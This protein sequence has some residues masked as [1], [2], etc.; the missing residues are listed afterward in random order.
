MKTLLLGFVIMAAMVTPVAVG[1]QQ[2]ERA[3]V[4]VLV[5]GTP[6]GFASYIEV[7]R[8]RLRELGWIEGQNLVLD[9]RYADDN[10]D[11]LP[12]LATELVALKPDAIFAAT[13]AATRAAARATDTIP[14]VFETLSDAVSLGLVSNL[15]RPERNVT[16]VSGFSPELAAKRLELVREI[17]PGTK[18]VAVLA[19][20][21]NPVTPPVVRA[22]ETA[23]R[24]LAV[25]LDLV[26]VRAPSQLENAFKQMAQRRP[27][28]LLLVA[29]PMLFGQSQQ[30]VEMAARHRLPAVYEQRLFTDLGGLLS[31][32]PFVNERFQQVAVYVDRILRG[33]KPA[34]LPIERPTKFELVVNLKT[35][36][37]LGLTIPESILLRADEV[38]R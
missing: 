9:V 18:R 32:G 28:A 1:A 10:Y 15:A 6:A 11:R 19:N 27:G 25:Q 13:A 8:L 20:R 38:I 2:G 30:I 17:V 35:A 31:Y 29:D 26:D 21:D 33:A 22:I 3:R 37:A 5:P 24:Q 7:F 36:K 14:I 4:G 12:A 34:E 23:A 16:G